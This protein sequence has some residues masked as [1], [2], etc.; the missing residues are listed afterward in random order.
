MQLIAHDVTALLQLITLNPNILFNLFK[1]LLREGK[2]H[3][4]TSI[5]YLTLKLTWNL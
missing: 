3:C 1:Y 4:H 2:C 5:N